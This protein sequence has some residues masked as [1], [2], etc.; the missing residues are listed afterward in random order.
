MQS[1]NLAWYKV[2][3]INL[4]S[5]VLYFC[6]DSAHGGQK[7]IECYLLVRTGVNPGGGTSYGN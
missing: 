7:R 6:L 2:F 3:V 1:V 4:C 5:C